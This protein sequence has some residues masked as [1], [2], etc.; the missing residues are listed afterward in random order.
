MTVAGSR[1]RMIGA[2]LVVAALGACGA[3]DP[4]R[5]T[6]SFFN[7]QEI[8]LETYSAEQIYERGEFELGR[9]KPDQA[10]FYFAEIERLYPYSE[11]AKR[12]L[13]M[14]AFAY[15]KDQDYPNS[16][17]AAQRFIDFFPDDDDAAYAQYLLALSYYDQIEEVGRDQ[18]L[19]F[20]ALQ[21]LRTVIENYPDSEYARAAILKFDLA[22]DHLAGKEME[23]GRYY[24]RRNHYT[25]S[26]NRFRV[27]VEDFQ[28]TSHTA[29][30]LHRLVE[31]YL[32]LGLTDE[33]QTAGAILGHN[34]RS[35]EWYQDSYRLLTGRGLEPKSLGDNWLS[36]IYRQTIK[37]EWI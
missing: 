36:A 29:E 37:G 3:N 26:I 11:W 16:R 21:A 7:P 24:L 32:S 20:Q 9:R 8:P 31:A 17:S 4:G 22:F 18:G 35:T 14:Q 15:H 5:T 12:A 2:V 1:K 13:I 27:V 25:A 19:T 33:A 30:A 34:Y 28:T 6:S 10:A 23:I